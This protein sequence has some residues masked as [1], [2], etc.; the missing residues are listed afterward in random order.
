MS[1]YTRRRIRRKHLNG[2]RTKPVGE[3]G[4]R[5]EGRKKSAAQRKP[6]VVHTTDPRRAT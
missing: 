4:W 3:T 1:Y 5:V 2:L 6:A